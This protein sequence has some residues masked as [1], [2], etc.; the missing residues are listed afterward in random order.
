MDEAKRM[1]LD[2]ACSFH[3]ILPDELTEDTPLTEIYYATIS[4]VKNTSK[5]IVKLNDILPIPNLTHLKRMNK[6]KVLL[7]PIL[8]APCNKVL[9][10]LKEKN[11]DVS[12]LEDDIR[13]AKVAKIPPRTKKQYEKVTKLW[14]CNFHPNKYLEKLVTNTL[15]SQ[16]ELNLHMKFMELAIDVAKYG[17]DKSTEKQQ[18]GVVIVDPKIESVVAVGYSCRNE[19]PTRHAVMVAIDNVAKTQTGGTWSKAD[20]EKFKDGL[21]INGFPTEEMLDHIKETYT[22][23]RFGATIFKRKGDLEQ[24]SDGPYLCTG[25]QVYATREP[26]V[27]CAMALVHSRAFRVFYGT[28]SENGGLETLCKVHTVQD[29]NHH[30]EVFAGLLGEE[31]LT[32]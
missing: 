2:P 18:V 10:I 26:C 6:G 17:K 22:D 21:D 1:K 16:K 13:I 32:L 9:N 8:A 15:F 27:M 24:P 5:I 7:L 3:P 4:D 30:Y 28:S 14:P 11:F 31:C 25:Y 29:L 20:P 23:L 19:G 12:T